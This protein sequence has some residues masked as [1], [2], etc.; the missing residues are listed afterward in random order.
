M[1]PKWNLRGQIL[2]R[3]RFIQKITMFQRRCDFRLCYTRIRVI[4]KFALTYCWYEL[5]L[6]FCAADASYTCCFTCFSIFSVARLKWIQVKSY[7][8]HKTAP[9]LWTNVSFFFFLGHI[10]IKYMRMLNYNPISSL[11]SR[12][13]CES[14]L[15]WNPWSRLF[16]TKINNHNSHDEMKNIRGRE[17]SPD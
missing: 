1:N 9:Y 4:Q 8:T 2:T 13:R 15:S 5:K 11:L 12:N 16:E 7:N 3:A 14:T 10:S 17:S 6:D